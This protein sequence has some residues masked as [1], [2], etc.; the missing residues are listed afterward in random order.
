[1]FVR[2]EE[3][4][5]AWSPTPGPR[6]R[7]PADGRCVIRHSA[8]LTRFA[9]V[10]HGLRH[11]LAVF[12]HA[13]D[14]VKF[15]LLTLTNE[16]ARPRRLSVFAYT[17]WL[18]GPPR[19]GQATHVATELDA[20]TEAVLATNAYNPEFAGRVAFA[21]ASEPLRSATADRASFLGRNGS[22]A[23]PAAL[24]RGVLSARF[25]SGLDAC[26]ALQVSVALLPGETRRLVFLVGQ[27]KDVDEGRALVSRH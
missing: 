19:Q 14:P 25:G 10:A 12:V 2:D 15:S 20:A 1:L 23:Q 13:R 4:A 24:R 9:R 11:E 6:R 26:A 8:G 5:R 18:L 22:I 21:H 3:T 17:E 16:G 27:G 7:T